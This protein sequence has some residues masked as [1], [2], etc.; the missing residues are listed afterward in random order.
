MEHLIIIPC[1]NEST[2][3]NKDA[4]QQFLNEQPNFGLC[5]VNDGSKDDTLEML[6]E[7]QSGQED[8]VKVVHLHENQGKAEA[9]RNGVWASLIFSPKTV[10]FI[11][12]DLSTDFEDYMKL[13]EI[14]EVSEGKTTMVFG[15]RK[16]SNNDNIKRSLFRKV[17]SGVVSVGIKS[18]LRLSIKD[19]QCGAKVFTPVAARFCFK[20]SFVSRWLFDVE[21]FIRMKKFLG[22]NQMEKVIQEI[23]LK[24]WIHVEGSKISLKDSIRIPQQLLKIAN[25]YYFKPAIARMKWK[26]GVQQR[27][28][29]Q[30]TEA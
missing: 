17:A 6:R 13:V 10:G 7:F 4:F 24:R 25:N 26:I 8:R 23:S 15:S 3:L 5:M 30:P 16:L 18:L 27:P 2:R 21:L 14:L 12:A 11:D 9:V 20:E 19:T 28:N 22:P 1:Y 29:Y